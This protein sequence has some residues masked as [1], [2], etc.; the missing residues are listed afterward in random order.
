MTPII[1]FDIDR[2]LVARS[3]AHLKAFITAVR[4]V[5]GADVSLSVNAHYGMTDQQ[6]LRDVLRAKNVPQAAIDAGLDRCLRVMTDRFDEYNRSDTVELL[7]GVT[8]LLGELA[9][10][11]CFLGLVTGN[12]E[13]IA[14]GK[15]GAAGIAHFFSF[16]GFGSDH[17]DRRELASLAVKRCKALHPASAGCPAVLF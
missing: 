7:P 6:I 13:T 1:L 5:Y 14:W 2:T 15:L 8:Q 10:R 11:R 16:G 12:L 17:M 4:E 9:Q 3:A